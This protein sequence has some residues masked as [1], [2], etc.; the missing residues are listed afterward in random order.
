MENGIAQTSPTPVRAPARSREQCQALHDTWQ[1]SALTQGKFCDTQGVRYKTFQRWCRRFRKNRRRM[2]YT[3]LRAAVLPIGTGD[4]ECTSKKLVTG[5]MK[6]CR[7]AVV[8]ASWSSGA[9]LWRAGA[10]GSI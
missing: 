8:P 2:Q 1:S 5:R 7:D 9:E 10:I 4:V 3:R 6:G